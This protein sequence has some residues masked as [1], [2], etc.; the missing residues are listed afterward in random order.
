MSSNIKTVSQAVFGSESISRSWNLPSDL[1]FGVIGNSIQYYIECSRRCS[2]I[3]SVS[4]LC[5][6]GCKESVLANNSTFEVMAF[7][8]A[9]SNSEVTNC[10]IQN[11]R[12]HRENFQLNCSL[13]RDDNT[14]YG[15]PL[16]F[17]NKGALIVVLNEMKQNSRNPFCIPPNSAIVQCSSTSSVELVPFTQVRGKCMSIPIRE[18]NSIAVFR[19]RNV[20]GYV[21]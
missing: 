15:I 20:F 13:C 8:P 5:V 11:C 6:P 18:N 10:P 7:G 12:F 19:G 9:I 2:K 1:D 21:D 14:K 17:T 16:L 3:S 4:T